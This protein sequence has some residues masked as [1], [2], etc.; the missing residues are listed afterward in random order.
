MMIRLAA[1]LFL[2]AST[3]ATAQD[4]LLLRSG[5]RRSGE[6]V[7]ADDTTIR[8][9]IS[10]GGDAAAPGAAAATIGIRTGPTSISR[11]PATT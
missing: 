2:A 10:L 8:L 4:F 6:I 9:R 5:E 11:R 3:L 1:L 7:S